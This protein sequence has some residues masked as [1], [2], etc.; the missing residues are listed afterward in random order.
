VEE[1]YS[2]KLFVVLSAALSWAFP[3]LAF[4]STAA[5][6]DAA[7]A[8]VAHYNALYAFQGQN[9]PTGTVPYAFVIPDSAGNLYGT[10]SSGGDSFTCGVVFELDSSGRYTVL[11]EFAGYPADG[12]TPFA[13]LFRDTEGT[14]YGTTVAGGP[15]E[16]GAVFKVDKAGKETVLHLFNGSDGAFPGAALVR[17]ARGNLYSMTFGCRAFN[18]N[19]QRHLS[20]EFRCQNRSGGSK[21]RC[22][23][24]LCLLFSP[25]SDGAMKR[26]I[27]SPRTLKNDPDHHSRVRVRFRGGSN[28]RT[29]SRSVGGFGTTC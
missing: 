20:Q 11:H 28:R 12:C 25:I 14:L 3:I 6:Q 24:A 21:F 9:A 15:L 18:I 22:S 29:V 17:D 7:D 13:G 26:N 10:T 23:H 2:C 5:S 16:Y 27:G 19:Y 4:H 8:A 1:G